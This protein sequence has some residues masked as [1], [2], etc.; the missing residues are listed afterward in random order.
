[1]NPRADRFD[2]AI[3]GG[4]ITGL[5]AAFWLSRAGAKVALLEARSELGGNLR[6]LSR[7]GWQFELGAST[8]L[9]K[10]A[11]AELLGAA[12]LADRRELPKPMAGRRWVW[13]DGL[14]EIPTGPASFLGSRL[15][16]FSSKLALLREPF[17]DPSARDE[18]VADFVR[19]RLGRPWLD[20]M[21]G[22]FVRGV[23][24]GDPE[25]LSL[26]WAFPKMA[27][28]ERE[29]GGL[30]RGALAKK[31]GPAPAEPMIGF[32]GGLGDL[33]SKLAFRVASLGGD[34]RTSAPVF[35]LARETGGYRLSI[36]GGSLL[37]AR[38]V[39]ATSAETTG[40]LL[41]VE[42]DARSLELAEVPYA[43]LAVVC[44]GYPRP[45]V[46]HA[47]DGFGFLAARGNGLRILG[48]QFTSSVFADRAPLG[49]VALTAYIGG[50]ND[51]S[52]VWAPDAEIVRL[53]QSDLAVA[54]G[55]YGEPSFVHVQRW[56]RA[57]PQ[58][59]MGH[60]R[61]AAL[62]RAFELD[63]PG[64]YLAGS[65]LD[66]V[67]VPDAMARGKAVALRALASLPASRVVP[68]EPTVARTVGA[69]A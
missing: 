66:G 27:A 48:C 59:E 19:R 54:I 22:P 1:M 13:R 62:A 58:Y 39:M 33:A 28:L 68:V 34:V 50:S 38:V 46:A 29:H 67:S 37:A 5:A 51:P 36:P 44:L 7:D 42:T 24:G 41:A 16:P 40:E 52:L 49:K 57:V 55:A 3:V 43:P 4:G 53:V 14:Q 11:V 21:V 65:W 20:A 8:L 10:P 63:L 15:V 64:T 45:H 69:R 17:I 32:R 56:P 26:Q 2:V 60:G 18:S 9:E 61:F 25:L 35:R 6:T 30:V 12:S 47:L 23:Y 31:R